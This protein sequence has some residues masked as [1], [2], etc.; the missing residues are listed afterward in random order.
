MAGEYWG[1]DCDPMYNEWKTQNCFI[2]GSDRPGL[3]GSSEIVLAD[4]G[5]TDGTYEVMWVAIGRAIRIVR[6][7]RICQS[8]GFD[9]ARGEVII[10]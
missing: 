6:L 7:R 8:A 5:S 9:M 4:D 1:L 3:L 10:A 2:C